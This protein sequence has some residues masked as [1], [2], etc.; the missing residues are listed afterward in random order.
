MTPATE[1]N[2]GSQAQ[3][4]QLEHVRIKPG[5]ILQLQL[6]DSDTRHT[7]KLIG[8]VTGKTI[9][10]TAPMTGQQLLLLREHQNLI[11]RFFSGTSVYEFNSTLLKSCSTP[12]AYLHLAYPKA[13]QK[14]S[15][16][17]STR[18]DLDIAALATNLSQNSATTEHP[19]TILNLS[20]SGAAI[21]AEKPLGKKDDQLRINFSTVIHDIPVP[22]SLECSIRS[23]SPMEN[24]R[25]RYGI[26]FH[27]MQLLDL[28][29][30]QSLIYQKLLDEE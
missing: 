20:L 9:L 14:N 21:T 25:I 22:L 1:H 23:V 12:L 3:H 4:I 15:I 30:V 11:L 24:G 7:V 2:A 29:T 19:I 16:R 26:Q 13:V 5:D 6:A 10:V 28:L 17:D 8:F 18:V 27:A